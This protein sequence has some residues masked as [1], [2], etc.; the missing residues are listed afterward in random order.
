LPQLRSGRGVVGREK[1][2]AV[3]V[4]QVARD[5]PGDDQRGAGVAA[6]AL[7]Q[8]RRVRRG[9]AGREKQRSVHVGQVAGGRAVAIVAAVIAREAAWLD[10]LDERGTGGGPVALPQLLP[11]RAIV[12]CEEQRPVHVYQ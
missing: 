1:Q 9:G 4:G 12:G 2:R 6:V 5:K 11:V 8:L 3:D 7:P 10:V